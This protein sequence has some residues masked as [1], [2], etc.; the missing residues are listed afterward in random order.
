MTTLS[1]FIVLIERRR[2]WLAAATSVAFLTLIAT[3]VSQTAHGA[4]L[5][6]SRIASDLQQV[7]SATVTPK[8][9]WAKDVNGVR[10]VK[11]LI[12]GTGTDPDLTPLRA[13]VLA[14]GGSVYYRYSSV[15]AL[16]A[17]LPADQVANIVVR[18]DVQGISPNRMTARTAST[19]EFSTGAMNLR[20]Y[21]GSNYTGLDGAGVGIA[22]LDSGIGWSHLNMTAADG[23]T[24]RVKKAVDFQKVG[25]A[26]LVGAKDW[27]PGID[28]STSLYPGSASAATYESKINAD[29]TNRSDLF[30]HG[31]HVASVAAGRGAHQTNDSSGIAPGATL[32]DVKVLDGNGYGQVSDV[33][34]GIDWVMYHA[35]EYNIRVMNLSLAADSTETWQTD[36]LA[37]AA[38]S[39][40]AAGITVVVAAG[41]FGQDPN[42]AERFGTVSSPGHDPSVITVGSANTKGSARRSDDTVNFFSSRGPTRGSFINAAG[43]RQVDN[44]LKPDLVAPGNKIVGAVA[45][46]RAG[47]AGALSYLPKTYTALSSAYGTWSQQKPKQQLFDLSGTSIAAPAVA[48][49]VALMLQANPGLTPPLIKAM[50]QYSAQPIAGANLLQQGA[51]L[52]NVDGAVK[53]AQALRT[54]IKT[55][56]EAAALPVGTNLLAS[57]KTMPAKTSTISGETFNWSRIAYAGG[58][59]IVSGDA[60]FTQFQPIWDHRLVWAGPV[61]QRYT[62]GYWPAASGVAANTFVKAISWGPAG[63]QTLLTAGVVQ[64]TSLAGA[65]SHR[66]VHSNGHALWLARFGQ[67]LRAHR[68]RGA[69]QPGCAE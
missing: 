6:P 2:L 63:D 43:L 50:L 53:L 28:A 65:S 15:A 20:S 34:A 37:R 7:I 3:L 42:G 10:M 1:N 25:D 9:S 44:L 16:S 57:G 12:V 21:N 49:T 64:A 67:R 14:K 32:Y 4:P 24:T 61:A 62:V 68:R 69:Q 33:L 22:V 51:G 39:A 19:L 13:D 29:G 58:N 23:K 8:V 48:G 26:T 31:T 60:L 17:L 46:D 55:A 5:A 52:L 56:L 45:S 11:V 38:R 27:I 41:N 40:V 59:Q 35:K 47:A 66:R 54:D 30:G 36:P 18:N